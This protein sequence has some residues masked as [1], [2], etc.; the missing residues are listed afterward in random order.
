MIA[1]VP[2]GAFHGIERVD[3][4]G[5]VGVFSYGSVV[6]GDRDGFDITCQVPHDF[7]FKF[8]IVVGIVEFAVEYRVVRSGGGERVSFD[9]GAAFC[10]FIDFVASNEVGENIQYSFDYCRF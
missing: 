1:I 7:I 2:E 8:I 3:G 4:R 5:G 6:L 10:I 9:G